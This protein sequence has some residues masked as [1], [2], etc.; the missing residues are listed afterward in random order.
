MSTRDHDKVYDPCKSITQTQY[1]RIRSLI[2]QMNADLNS[3]A[4]ING[5]AGRRSRIMDL[6]V[7]DDDIAT[8]EDMVSVIAVYAGVMQSQ[9]QKENLKDGH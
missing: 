8:L 5:D 3:V 7:G 2:A 6:P 1:D 4:D 9:W